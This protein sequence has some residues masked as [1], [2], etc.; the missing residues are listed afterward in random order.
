[1]TPRDLDE[2]WSFFE[3]PDLHKRSAV[4][5][6][7]FVLMRRAKIRA[8]FPFDRH[9]ATVGCR[10]AR[11]GEQDYRGDGSRISNAVSP[12]SLVTVTHPPYWLT[13]A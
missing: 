3:R 12:G 2:A 11:K 4:D 10:R 5:A 7:S 8:A 1:V 13:S 6:V 9:F